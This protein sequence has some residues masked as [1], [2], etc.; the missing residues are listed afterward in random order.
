[1]THL[2][3]TQPGIE[4]FPLL[5][6]ASPIASARTFSGQRL[7][8]TNR[9]TAYTTAFR[10]KDWASLYDL[11][12]DENKISFNKLDSSQNA[13]GK[14]LSLYVHVSTQLHHA[15]IRRDSST[16]SCPQDQ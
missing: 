8:L 9:L 14:G 11:V 16:F 2:G 4:L 7:A 12:S 6:A 5:F 13:L 10:K 15:A 1:M 3:Q